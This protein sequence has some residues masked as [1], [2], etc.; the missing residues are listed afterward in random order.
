[1]Y[2]LFEGS[3]SLFPACT[4]SVSQYITVVEVDDENPAGLIWVLN[5]WEEKRGI[6]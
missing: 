6:F 4:V 5:M 1:M 2:G 3:W